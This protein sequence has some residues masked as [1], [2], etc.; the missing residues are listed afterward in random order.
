MPDMAETDHNVAPSLKEPYIL[1]PTATAQLPLQ[2]LA[3]ATAATVAL[4]TT[5]TTSGLQE[6]PKYVYGQ[7][8]KHPDD[9]AQP[10]TAHPIF[11]EE[12]CKGLPSPRKS[13]SPFSQMVETHFHDP[14]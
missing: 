10:P 8:P 1:Y 9:I 11:R 6:R 5:A 4:T 14:I 7:D 2:A 3:T 13:V 12:W